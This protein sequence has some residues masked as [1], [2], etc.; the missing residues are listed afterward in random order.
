M[1]AVW[2]NFVQTTLSSELTS[3]GTTADIVAATLPFQTPPDPSTGIGYLTLTDS[4][5]T[6]T[7]FEIISY[8]GKTGSGPYTL[9]GL[10]R[11]LE[12]SSARTWPV[13]T[14]VIQYITADKLVDE[15]SLAAED[16]DTI[17]NAGTF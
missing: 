16:G 9:T 10:T 17:F 6:P 14:Y 8:T 5:T 15:L 4:L 3:G 11:A 1:A 12:G 7:Y 2:N 13:G